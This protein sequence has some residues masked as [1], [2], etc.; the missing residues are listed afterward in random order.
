M[1]S[2]QLSL[3]RRQ[4]ERRGLSPDLEPECLP[5]GTFPRDIILYTGR[6]IV[7]MQVVVEGLQQ[8]LTNS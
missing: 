6:C 1:H 7:V 2:L 5:G 8:D 3:L 4:E